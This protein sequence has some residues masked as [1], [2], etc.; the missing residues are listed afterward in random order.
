MHVAHQNFLS[1]GIEKMGLGSSKLPSSIPCLCSEYC[2]EGIKMRQFAFR[3]AD[4]YCQN[5]NNLKCTLALFLYANGKKGKQANSERDRERENASV[6]ALQKD[7]HWKNPL[8]SFWDKLERI[9]IFWET[10]LMGEW[11]RKDA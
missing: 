8:A 4:V 9:T 10:I 3:S 6:G 2:I 1:K 11:D 7:G 5:I